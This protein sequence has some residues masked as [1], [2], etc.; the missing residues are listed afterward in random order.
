MSPVT[1][2]VYGGAIGESSGNKI[3]VETP[4]RTWL[5]DFGMGFATAGRFFDEFLQPRGALG[6]RDAP[7]A[8]Q[9]GKAPVETFLI[10]LTA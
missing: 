3:L 4:E 7:R 6:L 2:T 1:R 8:L 9:P 5:L 10:G